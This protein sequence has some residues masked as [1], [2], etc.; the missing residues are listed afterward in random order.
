MR[1]VFLLAAVAVAIAATLIA[2]WLLLVAVALYIAAQLVTYL[3]SA[4]RRGAHADQTTVSIIITIST[5]IVMFREGASPFD[6]WEA[7]ILLVLL[8]AA[9]FLRYVLRIVV[10]RRW[11]A[12]IR[13]ENLETSTAQP[14]RVLAVAGPTTVTIPVWLTAPIFAAYSAVSSGYLWVG[15]LCLAWAIVT[16]IPIVLTVMHNRRLP[17]EQARLDAALEALRARTPEVLVHFNGASANIYALAQWIPTL[18]KL[19][20]THRVV[21]LIVDRQP[22]HTKTVISERLPIV[23]LTGAEAIENLV[24]NVPSLV[25]AFY[26]RTTA[27]NKNLLRVPGLYDIFVNHGESDKREEIEPSARAFDEIWVAGPA[28]RD[29]YL[30]AD[31]GVR[32]EQVRLVGRPQLAQLPRQSARADDEG[33]GVVYAPTWE[34]AFAPDGYSSLLAMGEALVANLLADPRIRLTY[35]PHP[36]VGSADKRFGLASGRIES[37]IRRTGGA[38]HVVTEFADRYQTLSEADVLVTDIST[39]LVDY[40]WL[41][42]PYI[43]TNPDDAPEFTTVNPSAGGGSVIAASA[44]ESV[45]AL[46]REAAERDPHKLA[47]NEVASSYLGEHPIDQFFVEADKSLEIARKSSRRIADAADWSAE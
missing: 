34:G 10:A 21:I 8:H 32:A 24:D 27:P 5:I 33:I 39:D 3:G 23:F 17:R 19:D 7:S 15:L 9:H 6:L 16:V 38:H 11:R 13:W 12:A 46:V 36:A 25:A 45:A 37:L 18:E 4:S 35:L 14:R 26:P 2:W 1:R 40:L 31:V 43:V 47:R 42:R 28:A 41:D 29:R 30:A 44:V 22:W 20:E